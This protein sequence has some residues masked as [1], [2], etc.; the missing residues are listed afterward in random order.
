[1]KKTPFEQVELYTQLGFVEGPSI[2]STGFNWVRKNATKLKFIGFVFVGD[3]VF[4]DF[5]LVV[6]HEKP[7]IWENMLVAVFF[8]SSNKQIQ[9]KTLNGG[10]CINNQST[11]N[12]P[13]V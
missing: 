6:Y 8:Q 2:C 13:V 3:F 1:M 12:Y 5:T 4:A 7:P 9:D 11:L 10:W